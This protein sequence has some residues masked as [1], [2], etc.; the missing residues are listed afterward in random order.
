M[1]FVHPGITPFALVLPKSRSNFW[2]AANYNSDVWDIDYNRGDKAK[3]TP[4]VLTFKKRPDET[5][6]EVE[7]DAKNNRIGVYGQFWPADDCCLAVKRNGIYAGKTLL[8]SNCC[9]QSTNLAFWARD[10]MP[11][12]SAIGPIYATHN[13][14]N[15]KNCAILDATVG[16]VWDIAFLRDPQRL[17][18]IGGLENIALKAVLIP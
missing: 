5:F 4:G 2:T 15:V 1:P 18:T 13:I 6:L 9:V 16:F 14:I 11:L 7:F 12:Y 10:V 8:A 3:N 17:C